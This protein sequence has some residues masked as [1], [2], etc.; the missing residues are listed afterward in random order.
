MK[1]LLICSSLFLA[2]AAQAKLPV[3]VLT[4]Q[5]KAAAEEAKAKTAWASKVDNYKLC[6]SMDRVA[7]HYFKTA[8]ATGKAV[9]PASAGAPACVDPGPFVYTPAAVTAAK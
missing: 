2:F 5:A 7:G 4:D 3:P 8:A 6:V 1:H 9:K